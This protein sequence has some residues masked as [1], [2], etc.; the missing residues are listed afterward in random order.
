M[1]LIEVNF[2]EA[3][4]RWNIIV[5]PT[6]LCRLQCTYWSFLYSVYFHRNAC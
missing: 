3:L 6:C 5:Q 4:A 1:M 2:A